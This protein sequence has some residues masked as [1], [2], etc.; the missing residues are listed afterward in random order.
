MNMKIFNLFMKRRDLWTNEPSS[1]SERRRK[2]QSSIFVDPLLRLQV[3]LD[4][5]EA[6]SVAEKHLLSSLLL[7][8]ANHL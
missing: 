4:R 3:G 2:L 1:S 7:L 6:S 8:P 5:L